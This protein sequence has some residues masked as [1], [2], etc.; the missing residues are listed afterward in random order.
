[1]ADAPIQ[2]LR[3]SLKLAD[4]DDVGKILTNL[5]LNIND[6]D[7][8]RNIADA[9]VEQS[10][11]R[12]LS[13]LTVDLDK[14][15]VAIFNETSTY[16]TILTS[17]NDGRR[18]VAGNLNVAGQIIA[19]SFKFNKVAFDSKISYSAVTTTNVIGNTGTGARFEVVR[20]IG[21]RG[22]DVTLT[23]LIGG[24]TGYAVGNTLNILGTQVG[25]ATTANDIRITVTG[26]NAGAITTF[27]IPAVGTSGNTT[28]VYENA[29]ATVDFSTS[30]SSAWSS[31][32]S[33]ATSI[34]YG[35][36][37][38]INGGTSSIELSSL[39]F[40][41]PIKAKRPGF[42][43]QLPTHKIR[44][45]IDGV[46]Y[47]L[48]AM[49]GIPIRFRGFFRTVNS[50]I[51]IDFRPIL[52]PDN[53]PYRPSWIL[54]NTANGIEN[55]IINRINASNSTVSRSSIITYYDSTSVERDI[56]FFY[57][58]DR[59]TTIY[60]DEVKIYNIP[61]AK[62]DSMNDLKIING[63]LIEMPDLRSL[64][65]NLKI[66]TLTNNDLTRSNTIGLR[67]FSS[68]VV[69][70]L[71]LNLET[72]TLNNNT[73]GGDCTAD[74]SLLTKL[75]T[76]NASSAAN[77]S[78]RMTGISPAIGPAMLSYNIS[79]NRFT[80]L[81]PSVEASNTLKSLVIFSNGISGA[82]SS[83]NLNSLETFASGGSNSHEL[84][85]ALNKANLTSYSSGSMAFPATPAPIGTFIF[86]GCKSLRAINVNSTNITGPLPNFTSN[87][88]LVSFDALNT[89]WLDADANFSIAADTFGSTGADGRA[90]MI[91]FE[92]RSDN[93]RKPIEP[94]AF[95]GMT[96]L[97]TL[98]VISSAVKDG[99]VG[100]D[101]NFPTS[102]S[103]CVSLTILN[104]NNNRLSGELPGSTFSRNT[105]L[106][107]INL[108]VNALTG[109]FPTLRL[110]S[111]T[112]L[113]ISN[114]KFTSLG[115]PFCAVLTS[116]NASDNL[117]SDVPNF[118][119]ATR[120]LDIF[121]SNNI[122]IKYNNNPFGRALSLRRLEMINCGLTQGNVNSIISDLYINWTRRQRSGV[123]INL[124]GNSPPSASSDITFKI[125]RLRRAGWTIGL[126]T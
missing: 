49:K 52:K 118:D 78:R 24:G 23:P 4:T 55:P 80:S 89:K 102:I 42:E 12:A 84:F 124:T 85:N 104:L 109:P 65:P 106:S 56:E 27:T 25:G 32:G 58:V 107:T 93:L 117:I 77:S 13:G 34:F 125:S 33:P 15:V 60:L 76:Y 59:I 74:L 120:I 21:T 53:Q 110:S 16:N 111:L 96:F 29:I 10:D 114:N 18:I 67:T 87:T 62:I 94:T 98:T 126:D 57:P 71:P 47:D 38:I 54:R 11:I 31:F 88:N 19:P 86:E 66:L 68:E 113:N 35:G 100:I 46:N 43:S 79:G 69:N 70:R 14:E 103:D 44:V 101:G 116:L 61:T 1:M 9:G 30:R 72:L 45:N 95:R 81:H 48:Y 123:T 28:R 83:A 75:T 112:S 115:A 64:Y 39:D 99:T 119:N 5:N 50:T 6:L 26:V 20:K 3:I 73:Y 22:Y 2:G 121:L 92:L 122:G 36:D 37:V 91:S 90:K 63:D 8:I 17:L 40:A 51:R 97:R 108:S 82:I 7:K 41:G 105:R